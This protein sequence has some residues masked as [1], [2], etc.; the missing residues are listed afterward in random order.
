MLK[1]FT[2]APLVAG[3]AL[4]ALT[5]GCEKR[6]GTDDT[7]DGTVASD[8]SRGGSS[9]I[10]VVHADAVVPSIDVAADDVRP[11]TG[12]A[13]KTVTPFKS[14]SDNLVEFEIRAAGSPATD[15]VAPL[16]ENREMMSDGDRYTL[17][18]LPPEVDDSSKKVRLRVLEEPTDA[19]D[20]NKARIRFVNAA[21]GVETFDVFTPASTTDPFF[22]DVDFGTEAGFK[23]M[24][25]G[26]ARLVV[27]GDDNGP[28][29]LTLPE[30]AYTA[31]KTYTFVLTNRS[32]GAKQL[33]V[34]T[35]EDEVVTPASRNDSATGRATRDTQTMR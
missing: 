28:V 26:S 10:R 35:I 27:R 16:A 23:D 3:L 18:V 24:D 19:G 4:L 30:R 34:I 11:F 25:A 21:R 29:L 33:E 17:V 13:F 2:R 8:S 5:A 32:A 22:D 6:N 12:V 1:T 7:A 14:I 20:A 31:G 15:S 9:M